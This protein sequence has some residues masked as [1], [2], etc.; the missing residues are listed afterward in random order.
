MPYF[1]ERNSGGPTGVRRS[2]RLRRCSRSPARR[3]VIA[4]VAV[5]HTAIRDALEVAA[6]RNLAGKRENP[7][8]QALGKLDIGW[9]LT[10]TPLTVA[11]RQRRLERCRPT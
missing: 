4:P 5:S 8:S 7:L 9:T 10:R 3:L 6:P 2:R 11:G 1:A